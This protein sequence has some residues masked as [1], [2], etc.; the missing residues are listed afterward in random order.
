MVSQG[1]CSIL[2]S[3]FEKR[4]RL[5]NGSQRQEDEVQAGQ[6]DLNLEAQVIN[7]NDEELCSLCVVT[8]A[9]LISFH[10]NRTGEKRSSWG[11]CFLYPLPAHF[12]LIL[13][14]FFYF[15]E[16]DE[17]FLFIFHWESHRRGWDVVPVGDF[18]SLYRSKLTHLEML[19]WSSYHA[20]P[21]GDTTSNKFNFFSHKNRVKEAGVCQ[22]C[23]LPYYIIVHH[24]NKC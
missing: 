2:V 19:P 6:G 13:L 9:L 23:H 10:S 17:W 11:G 3:P 1:T 8:C 15:S 14:F 21:V 20:A 22:W 12:P 16:A 5:I 4:P 24:E 18:R 7:Q